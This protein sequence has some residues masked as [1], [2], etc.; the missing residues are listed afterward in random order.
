MIYN[1][2]LFRILKSLPKLKA[3]PR[4]KNDTSP[5]MT[6]D[7]IFILLT[8]KIC[9]LEED[10]VVCEGPVCDV[11]LLL[12][13]ILL[14]STNNVCPCQCHDLCTLKLRGQRWLGIIK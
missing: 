14:C 9:K 13:K 6:K 11:Y 4:A 7:F 1:I 5:T 10:R 8:D 2:V 3:D 12:S